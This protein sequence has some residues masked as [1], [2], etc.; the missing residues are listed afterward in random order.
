M[1]ERS[2]LVSRFGRRDFMRYAGMV[3]VGASGLLAACRQADTGPGTG[4]NGTSPSAR[5]SID[6]EPGDLRIYEWLGYGDGSYGDDILW[7]DYKQQGYPAPK[8]TKTFDDDAGYTKV[9]AG[10]RWDIVHPCAYRFEDWVNLQDADGSP[11]MQP[12]DTSLISTYPELNPALQEFGNIDGDQYFIV[13]DWGFAAPMYR[14]DK[15]QPE[16]TWGVLFDEQY[17]GRISWWDSL[18]M[19]IV[20]AYLNG[21]P[22]PWA[23]TDQELEQQ[24]DF[25]ISKVPLVRTFWVDD[26]APDLVNGDVDVAYAWPNHWWAAV[27]YGVPADGVPTVYM[28]PKEGRTSWYCGFALFADTEN[29][30]HAHEYVSAWTGTRAAE[31]LINNYAY[32]H[33]NTEVDLS[34][35]NQDLVDAFSLDD[36]DVLMEPT[37]H[38]ERPIEGRDRYNELWLEVKAAA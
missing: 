15:I 9:A 3:G 4:G 17:K 33:T 6:Q 25:L 19:F 5:P 29:Y 20:A 30:H 35:V 10:E 2:A 16:N 37:S 22:D 38:P 14:S 13:A 34:T 8:F 28:D 31:W 7:K 11:V 27:G 36:P 12:W 24:R 23:M 1:G 21:V 18:N 32:G 26:P